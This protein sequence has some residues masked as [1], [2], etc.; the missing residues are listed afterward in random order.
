[1]PLADESGRTSRDQ[2]TRE[3]AGGR[4][5][6][7]LSRAEDRTA[8]RQ[9]LARLSPRERILLHLRFY[10]GLSQARTARRLGVSQMHV[11]RWENRAIEK[12]RRLIEY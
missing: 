1:M 8:V 6:E 3:L 5:D 11:S 2:E 9:M 12:L 10:E 7:E 4:E